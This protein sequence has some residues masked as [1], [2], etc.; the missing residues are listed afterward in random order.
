MAL[1]GVTGTMQDSCFLLQVAKQ[2]LQGW[3][4]RT[5]GTGQVLVDWTQPL[6]SKPRARQATPPTLTSRASG[7][8]KE[9]ETLPPATCRRQDPAVEAGRA[10]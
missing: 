4:D 7:G 5:N 1:S 6:A 8:K 2:R 10:D 9:Q 3:R